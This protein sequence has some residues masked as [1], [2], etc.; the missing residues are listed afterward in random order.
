MEPG[1]QAEL[2]AWLAHATVQGLP[3]TTI[4]THVCETLFRAGLP[5]ERAHVSVTTLHPT[6]S[7]LGFTW[8]PGTATIAENYAHAG[9]FR[10]AWRQSPFQHM[11]AHDLGSMR[12]RLDRVHPSIDFPI[13]RDFRREGL[14][15]WIALRQ[16]FD[17]A[18]PRTPFGQLGMI[19]SWSTGARDGFQDEHEAALRALSVP[20]AAAAKSLIVQ[21]ISRDVLAAYIGADAA[22][23]VLAG[24]VTR[25]SVSEIPAVILLADMR[26]FTA[27]SNA[28][29]TGEVIER[30]NRA[31]DAAA[32]PIAEHGGQILKFM[33][34][35]LLAVFLT[36]GGDT[37]AATA[38]R[39]LRAATA[40]QAHA[41]PFALDVVVH[42]G[43]VHYGNIG[44]SDRLDFTVIG[45]AV[46]ETSRMEP[47]CSMLGEPI[48]V[49]AKVAALMPAGVMRS[50]GWHALRGFEAPREIFA[51][52]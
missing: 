43:E 31:F 6:V 2:I 47:L 30:L 35:A 39:A 29:P 38:T 41:G 4:H 32:H 15:D 50:C 34:D 27:F 20:L 25:G 16:M 7:G 51:P 36:G 26:G 45:P 8:R 12:V 46:N 10:P 21:D 5:L 33:G 24:E 9:Y 28:H 42:V 17:W 44:A 1:D 11:M 19:G 23:R 3:F 40:I 22:E 49:S 13:F 52:A 14:T 48:L 37:L 18:A